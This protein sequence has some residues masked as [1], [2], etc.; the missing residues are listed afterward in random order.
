M[1]VV[2]LNGKLLTTN[3]KILGAN[4][5][6]KIVTPSN[7]RQEI[8]ADEGYTCLGKVNVEPVTSAIDS[9]IIPENIK[10]DVSIL[11]VV[12]T[13][14]A[15]EGLDIETGKIDPSYNSQYITISG[16][17][18]RPRAALFILSEGAYSN[19]TKIDGMAYIKGGYHYIL[20][21]RRNSSM[22]YNIVSTKDFY[23]SYDSMDN[24][25]FKNSSAV[26]MAYENGNFYIKRYNNDYSLYGFSSPYD[27][28]IV[29]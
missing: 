29:Y 24:A 27:Y 4:A 5:Q 21:T 3:D 14:K 13:L 1:K 10:K 28:I 20:T 9:N 26:K 6:E 17:K 12:G 23:A 11:G 7:E 15:I 8:T 2:K 16:L 25:S 22:N 18:A 19:N